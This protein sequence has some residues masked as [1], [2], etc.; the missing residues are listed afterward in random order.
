VN[1]SD[2]AKYVQE[3]YSVIK[4]RGDTHA[5]I[6]LDTRSHTNDDWYL[7]PDTLSVLR[8]VLKDD[9]WMTPDVNSGHETFLM[10]RP[11]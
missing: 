5:C 4:S 7:R 2:Q 11:G 1:F 6:Y 3:A 8:E 10:P 9:Y